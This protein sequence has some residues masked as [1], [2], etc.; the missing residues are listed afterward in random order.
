MLDMPDRPEND[1]PNRENDTLAVEHGT[2][3]NELSINYETEDHYRSQTNGEQMHV[4]IHQGHICF[5]IDGHTV[6][7]GPTG[8]DILGTNIT[9]AAHKLTATNLRN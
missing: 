5:T 8:A 9:R 1:R 4:Y 6:A 7:L 2:A 3:F